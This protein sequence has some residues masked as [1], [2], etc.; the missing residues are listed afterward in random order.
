MLALQ[1]QYH[2]LEHSMTHTVHHKMNVTITWLVAC[3][4]QKFFKEANHFFQTTC[5]RLAGAFCIFF[6]IPVMQRD[7]RMHAGP[8]K[9][10]NMFYWRC[11]INVTIIQRFKCISN[12]IEISIKTMNK[13]EG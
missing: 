1:F 13:K 3:V 9:N 2:V 7:F 12:S 8:C 10:N 4:Y 6:I 5:K 11:R